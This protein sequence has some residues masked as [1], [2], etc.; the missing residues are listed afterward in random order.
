MPK[1]P[2]SSIW[3]QRQVID[4]SWKPIVW[5]KESG[6]W[7]PLVEA[8]WFECGEP[9]ATFNTVCTKFIGHEGE[10]GKRDMV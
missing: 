10:H 7:E 2:D 5:N 4:G 3:W 8:T 1:I 9:L 6:E